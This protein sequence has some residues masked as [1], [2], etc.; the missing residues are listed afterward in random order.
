[1]PKTTGRLTTRVLDIHSGRP[2][3]LGE[4]ATALV[5]SAVTNADG[6]TDAPLLD[7]APL[8]VGRYELRFH[9]GDYFAKQNVKLSDPP[10]FDVVPVRFSVAD[11]EGHC[12]VP[13]LVTPWNYATYRGS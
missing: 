12:H 11:P 2:A 9:V 13:L 10:F 7:G 6:R 3:A 8:R 1:M 5:A 4:G